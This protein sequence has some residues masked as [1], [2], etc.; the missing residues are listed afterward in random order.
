MDDRIHKQVFPIIPGLSKV[1]PLGM[2]QE[3]GSLM[4]QRGRT[5]LQAA[6]P[7]DYF[8]LAALLPHAVA[9]WGDVHRGELA[10]LGGPTYTCESIHKLFFP[11]KFPG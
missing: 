1:H 10:Y 7:K 8:E 5:V 11:G 2:A 6:D 4:V 3:P 9:E